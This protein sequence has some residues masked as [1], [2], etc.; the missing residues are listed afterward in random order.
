[1]IPVWLLLVTLQLIA[2]TPLLLSLMP[3]GFYIYL[4]DLLNIMRL[5]F[6]SAEASSDGLSLEFN[7]AGYTSQSLTGNFSSPL[8]IM[9]AASTALL[10][11][12]IVVDRL[13]LRS[14]KHSE[15]YL[16]ARPYLRPF[17]ALSALAFAYAY[18]EIALCCLV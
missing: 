11:L 5:K 18:L 7:Q 14:E 17:L 3:Q 6:G 10:V 4:R 16:K 8:S 13:L 2:H 12:L 9:L 1:M 15:K